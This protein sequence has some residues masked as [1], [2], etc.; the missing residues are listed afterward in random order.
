M[1]DSESSDEDDKVKESEKKGWKRTR[2]VRDIEEGIEDGDITL[3]D[4]S[5]VSEKDYAHDKHARSTPRSRIL[6]SEG[7]RITISITI[8]EG[9]IAARKVA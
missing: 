1:G 5:G 8:V 4:D 9:T 6:D 3:G 2:K 7:A